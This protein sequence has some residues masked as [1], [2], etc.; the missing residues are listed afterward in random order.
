M[1]RFPGLAVAGA[2]AF[3]IGSPA[4]ATIIS[5]TPQG[6]S[7][8]VLIINNPC[9]DEKDG[10]ALLIT[11]CLN[12]SHTA[13]GDVNFTSN[14]DIIFTPGGGQARVQAK[15]GLTQ[16][17]GIDPVF[18]SLGK[19]ILDIHAAANGLVQ[20]CDNGGCFGTL[21]DLDK[22]GQNFFTL[23]FNPAADFVIFNTFGTGLNDPRQ[24][25][26]D[27]RQWRVGI[28]NCTDPDGDCGGGG[29]GPPP[30]PEPASLAL[31]GAALLGF[32]LFGSLR[33]RRPRA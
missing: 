20:F 18:F 5:V 26:E 7:T 27:T 2:M 33:T 10:P 19:L 12:K 32:S 15:D 3:L 6:G 17:I 16:T 28:V 23:A 25:I 11:G 29:G 14:E 22:N 24:L 30:V 1:S 31:L 21:F 9:V 13:G 8:G 4:S